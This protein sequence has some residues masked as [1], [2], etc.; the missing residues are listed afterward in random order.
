MAEY[1]WA[2]CSMLASVPLCTVTDKPARVCGDEARLL[3]EWRSGLR[4]AA[5]AA[6]D[7]DADG[8]MAVVADTDDA[9]DDD[10]T[11]DTDE[12]DETDE[13]ED[14]AE[15]VIVPFWSAGELG[16]RGDNTPAEAWC[17][18]PPEPTLTC[19]K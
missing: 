14:D 11:D 9:D 18:L 15:R 7:D 13:T 10:E 1:S 6:R 5:A 4:A 8:V 12:T 2:N 17:A 19:G 16:D 3:P